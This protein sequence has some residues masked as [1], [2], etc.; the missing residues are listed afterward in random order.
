MVTEQ[1]TF[2]FRLL[3]PLEAARDGRTMP[4]GG[5][6][7]RGVLA[8]LLVDVGRTVSV[9]ALVDELWGERAPGDAHRTVRTYV[10]RLRRALAG[11]PGEGCGPVLVTRP[12][13]YQLAVEPQALDAV[14]FERLATE[15]RRALATG[16]PGPA[17]E[18]LTAALALWRGSALAEFEGLPAVGCE[19]VRLN[20]LR[21][22]VVEDRIEAALA[23]GQHALLV[24]ELEGLVRAHPVRERLRGQLMI[25]LYR[26]GRQADAL[27]AFQDARTVLVHAYGVEPS[28]ALAGIHQRILRQEPDLT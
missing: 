14:R 7:V 6:R 10:S 23:T 3:G 28:P 24:G 27:G 13:G 19:A 20:A 25:A 8:R 15:G 17:L 18:V 1:G 5:P 4:L 12:P 21:L 11:P 16:R 9:T 26:S 2:E 22:T